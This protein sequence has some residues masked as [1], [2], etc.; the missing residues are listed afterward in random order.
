MISPD[1]RTTG[2]LDLITPFKKVILNS[3]GEDVWNDVQYELQRANDIRNELCQIN[4]VKTDVIQLRKFK[5]LYLEHYKTMQSLMNNFTFGKDSLNQVTLSVLWYDSMTLQQHYS[6]SLYLDMA[7]SLFNFAVACS[8]IACYMDLTGDGIKEASRFFQQAAWALDHCKTFHNQLP[9]GAQY[10]DFS[11]DNLNM[12]HNLM[13]AQAQYLFYKK[14][15]DNQM[16]AAVVCKIAMQVSTY[17]GLAFNFGTANQYT[18]NYEKG[19][20]LRIQDYHTGYFKAIA[21]LILGSDELKQVASQG[22]GMAKA[23]GNLSKAIFYF[24]Q[25]KQIVAT[26]PNAY[27]DNFNSKLNE[28]IQLR[29]QAIQQ[30]RTIYFEQDIPLDQIPAIEG[31]NLVQP[32]NMQSILDTPA[33]I[34][35]KL[36]NL[37]SPQIKMEVDTLTQQ[38]SQMIH[39]LVE[40]DQTS[41]DQEEVFMRQYRVKELIK[42]E[43]Q[44]QNQS[45]IKMPTHQVARFQDFQAK[46]GLETI[47]T[48]LEVIEVLKQTNISMMQDMK[49]MLNQEEQSDQVNRIKFGEKWLRV[50]SAKINGPFKFQIDEF[51]KKS[52]QADQTDLKIATKYKDQLEQLEILKLSQDEIEKNLN[53]LS[54]PP[55]NHIGEQVRQ[56]LS[57]LIDVLNVLKEQRSQIVEQALQIISNQKLTE[58]FTQVSSGNLRKEDVFE[59]YNQEFKS[60][61]NSFEELESQRTLINAQIETQISAQNFE[62]NKSL[63]SSSMNDMQAT[64]IEYLKSIDEKLQYVKELQGMLQQANT[65]HSTLNEHLNK[66][67]QNIKDMKVSRDLEAS[68]II[69][70]IE[71]QQ[72]QIEAQ[73]NKLNLNANPQMQSHIQMNPNMNQSM[74][75]QQLTNYQQQQLPNQNMNFNNGSNNNMGNSMPI[76]I[77][78]QMQQPQLQFVPPSSQQ[79]QLHQSNVGQQQFVGQQVNHQSNPQNFMNDQQKPRNQNTIVQQQQN[80]QPQMQLQQ[81]PQMQQQPIQMQQP[82]QFQGQVQN[83]FGQAYQ[84]Q[85]QPQMQPPIGQQPQQ[86]QPPYSV[87]G[88]NYQMQAPQGYI[89][90][91]GQ[92]MLQPMGQMP[93]S[94]FIHQQPYYQPPQGFQPPPGYF[95]QPP[96]NGMQQQQPQPQGY[97]QAPPGYIPPQNM[98]NQQQFKKN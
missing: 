67:D 82:Q 39:K 27:L 83:Q 14:A 13:L 47:N 91:Q 5:D 6:E 34:N 52:Q 46:G 31:H 64:Q 30:N 48:Q 74:M 29:D 87:G 36:K 78:P 94:Q 50:E 60:L 90:P 35:E 44:Q 97:Y 42:G 15:T 2:P 80:Q 53:N 92:Y 70:Q 85:I 79:N 84:Q 20:F 17:F 59:K 62:Q 32:E 21:H 12:L 1:F 38:F 93:P 3:N 16:K 58:D 95:Q 72:K 41:C 45:Q 96:M 22:Q 88:A 71:T 76:V 49:E 26:L 65:F 9:V 98:Q 81:Q 86:F 55:Q 40:Q 25:V 57:K 28:A 51:T 33:K 18:R 7:S 89:P 8:R 4:N 75:Q 19:V 43:I 73:L 24:E 37:I 69:Q 77:P 54:A 23:I 11:I 56:E 63:N 10:Q 68:D 66:L 61:Q